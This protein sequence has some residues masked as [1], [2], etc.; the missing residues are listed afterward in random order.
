MVAN[1]AQDG[2][3]FMS[4]EEY[5]ELDAGSDIRYEY[6]DGYAYPLTNDPTNLA[7]GS[8]A[9]ARV[10]ANL[11]AILENALADANSNCYVYTS[12]ARVQLTEDQY[13]YPD[14]SVACGE[15]ETSS[16]Q[17][18]I[19]IIEV[20]SPSTELRD[21]GSK[22]KS[23]RTCS[24]VEEYMLVGSQ[25][26]SIEVYRREKGAFARYHAY[27]PGDTVELTSVGV[28]FPFERVYRGVRFR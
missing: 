19:L 27:G 22:L 6:L 10:A 7:G 24:S 16:I 23:Y 11:I 8:P 26:K 18:P 3:R 13:L 17:N 12:D 15:E 21:R 14:V 9:H 5:L 2:G 20:L 25:Y 1:R 28:S 4:V